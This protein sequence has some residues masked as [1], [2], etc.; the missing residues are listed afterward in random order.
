MSLCVSAV[1]KI[2]LTACNNI[3]KR[4]RFQTNRTV[5]LQRELPFVRIWAISQCIVD[6]TYFQVKNVLRQATLCR[7]P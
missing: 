2:S 4:L 7:G 5:R 3:K 6:V 1:L